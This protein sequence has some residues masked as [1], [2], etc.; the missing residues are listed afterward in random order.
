MGWCMLMVD[1]GNLGGGWCF[2][3]WCIVGICKDLLRGNGHVSS[4]AY[5]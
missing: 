5:E 1:G 4:P 3:G 2:V